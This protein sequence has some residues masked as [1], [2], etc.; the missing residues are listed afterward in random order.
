MKVLCDVS[1]LYRQC[2]LQMR[3]LDKRGKAASDNCRDHA[4]SVVVTPTGD[5]M[6]RCTRHEGLLTI[7]GI[8]GPVERAIW[9]EQS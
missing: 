3:N 2:S 8:E 6:W 4:T 7:G 1:S 9:W 5:K